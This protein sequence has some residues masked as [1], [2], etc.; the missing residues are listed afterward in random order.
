[1]FEN[2]EDAKVYLNTFMEYRDMYE[3]RVD[4]LS[5]LHRKEISDL[6]NKYDKSITIIGITYIIFVLIMVF[7]V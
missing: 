7:Y 2:R 5:D 4:T 6:K 3:K 1:M